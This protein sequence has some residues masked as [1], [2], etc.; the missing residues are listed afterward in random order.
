MLTAVRS[1]DY[2]TIKKLLKSGENPCLQNKWNETPLSLLKN[3][4][5]IDLSYY[6]DS[7]YLAG[8]NNVPIVNNYIRIRSFLP[9]DD[10]EKIRQLYKY[11]YDKY[12]SE[13][14]NIWTQKVLDNDMKDILEYYGKGYRQQTAFW[15]VEDLRENKY[16]GCISAI[17]QHN[18]YNSASKLYE[19][20]ELRR[21]AIHPDYQGSG[22]GKFVLQHIESW[23]FTSGQ[24]QKIVLETL[25]E[26]EQAIRFY[27]KMG[28]QNQNQNHFSVKMGYQ[29]QKMGYRNVATFVKNKPDM[30]YFDIYSSR[31]DSNPIFPYRFTYTSYMTIQKTFEDLREYNIQK[32]VKDNCNFTIDYI[33]SESTQNS[34]SES[35]STLCIKFDRTFNEKGVLLTDYFNEVPRMNGRYYKEDMTPYEQFLQPEIFNKIVSKSMKK[36]GNTSNSS[37]RQAMYGI[38]GGPNIFRP[39]LSKT[40]L[41]MLNAT[42]ILD[43]CAGWGDRLLGAMAVGAKR[44]LGFDPNLNLVEGYSRMIHS[45]SG[46][47]P[48][49][50]FEINFIPFEDSNLLPDF[51]TFDCIL[52]SPPFFDIEIYD[53]DSNTQSISTHSSFDTWLNDWFFKLLNK[54]WNVLEPNGHMA[55]YINDKID[56]DGT[57]YSICQPM[58]EYVK[59]LKNSQFLGIVGVESYVAGKYRSLFVWKKY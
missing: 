19:S 4:S 58:V 43:P 3:K 50:K 13:R 5:V 56:P 37:L 31:L 36:Y 15:V 41:S 55:I 53:K 34:E 45:F 6:P 33:I 48:D 18:S 42:K 54:S 32:F 51:E 39:N 35:E 38:I 28:Y 47:F 16:I 25:N 14:L 17:P 30:Q 40:I 26:M 20:C 8:Y 52:T 23:I 22:I 2:K 21:F 29:N 12:D 11:T 46:L 9:F 24:Y 27:T 49:S 59:T 7:S 44:Y 10:N 1:N 57:S